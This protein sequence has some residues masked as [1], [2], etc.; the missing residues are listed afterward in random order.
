[1]SALVWVDRV[2]IEFVFVVTSIE[3]ASTES[4]NRARSELND[5]LAVFIV[6]IV[7]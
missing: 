4:L 2:F 5:V 3:R 7:S 6:V 1:M